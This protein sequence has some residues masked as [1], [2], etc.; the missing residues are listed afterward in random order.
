MN[1]GGNRP[2]PIGGGLGDYL[3]ILRQF[4]SRVHGERDAVEAGM[5]NGFLYAKVQLVAAGDGGYF[6]RGL[7]RI[8]RGA[9]TWRGLLRIAEIRFF[10]P[11]CRL[12]QPEMRYCHRREQRRQRQTNQK[13][14]SRHSHNRSDVAI[15]ENHPG[16]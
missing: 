3:G 1:R 10:Y 13:A 16:S 8:C 7:S 15:A 11:P 12:K 5:K 14:F 2:G 9:S 6:P 4:V